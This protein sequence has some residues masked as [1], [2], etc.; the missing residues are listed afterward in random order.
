VSAVRQAIQNLEA[1]IGR[2]ETGLEE[3]ATTLKGQQRDMFPSSPS[4][5][6]LSEAPFNP[7]ADTAL[8]AQKIDSAIN[9][10]EALLRGAS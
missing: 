4:S 6:P 3:A 8:M 5:P 7:P 9:K 2:L 1:A 10:V